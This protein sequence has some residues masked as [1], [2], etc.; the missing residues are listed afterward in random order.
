[1]KRSERQR[2]VRRSALL[3]TRLSEKRSPTAVAHGRQY[4][5]MAGV[6][7]DLRKD[8]PQRRRKIEVSLFVPDGR[9]IPDDRHIPA[10]LPALHELSIHGR[11]VRRRHPA[12]GIARLSKKP[13]PV[14]ADL[15]HEEG[16]PGGGGRLLEIV[17]RIVLAPA[18]RIIGMG[19]LRGEDAKID[20]L[21]SHGRESAL[22]IIVEMGI[23]G[24][25]PDPVRRMSPSVFPV[26]GF[27]AVFPESPVH[28]LQG[29]T[30]GHLMPRGKVEDIVFR[31]QTRLFPD[32]QEGKIGSSPVDI[33]MGVL[34]K[35]AEIP[36]RR[37]KGNVSAQ[38][39]ATGGSAESVRIPCLSRTPPSFLESS[40][41]FFEDSCKR[42]WNMLS[43]F[44]GI[45]P[46]SLVYFNN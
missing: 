24:H 34:P 16:C 41:E 21:H 17:E 22:R 40:V 32:R 13:F 25:L 29:V 8:R 1:M 4:P 20:P 15:G 26:T 7:A 35:V 30:G 37:A 18:F 2:L 28:L 38:K 31:V 10:V 27:I 3:H 44:Y 46:E 39:D 5:D 11:H 45:H 36:D 19:I 6:L 33:D 42:F 43:I 23:Y 12:E 14:T 9:L